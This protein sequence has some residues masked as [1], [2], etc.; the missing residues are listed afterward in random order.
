MP[1]YQRLKSYYK[2]W[3]KS[4]LNIKEIAITFVNHRNYDL[5]IDDIRIPRRP[6]DERLRSMIA[7]LKRELFGKNTN[8]HW[9][10]AAE[11]LQ[12]DRNQQKTATFKS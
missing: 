9:L 5:L 4:C 12:N 3:L 6:W 8:K 11:S 7:R 10:V 2:C 1:D